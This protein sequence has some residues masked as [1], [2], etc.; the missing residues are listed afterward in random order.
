MEI[1]YYIY[2]IT[3]FSTNLILELEYA[4]EYKN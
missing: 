3:N 4:T 2:N 1:N